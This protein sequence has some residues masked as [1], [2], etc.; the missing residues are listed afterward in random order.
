MANNCSSVTGSNLVVRAKEEIAYGQSENTGFET[1]YVKSNSINFSQNEVESEL[2]TAGR[3][4]SRTGK[5]NIEVTGSLE[6]AIDNVSTGF[7]LKQLLGDY[8]VAAAGAKFNHTFKISDTCTPSFQV[9]KGLLGTDI[10]Y[11]SVGL[12]ANSLSLD[13]GGEGEMIGTVDVIGKNEYFTSVQD[14]SPVASFSVD[15]AIN[16][17]NITLVDASALSAGDTVTLAVKKGTVS[18]LATAGNSVIA[19][20]AGEGVNFASGNFIKLG[21]VVYQVKAVSTDLLYLSRSLEIDVTATTIVLNV[22][23]TNKIES[24]TGNDIVLVNGIKQALV[25][26]DDSL[27]GIA[28]VAVLNDQSFEH[29]EVGITSTSGDAI[30]ATVETMAFT[31]ANNS[32]GKRLLN[33]KGL[34]GKVFDGK[35]SI[36]CELTLLFDAS[37]ARFIEE[38]K[39]GKEFDIVIECV[40]NTG[41]SLK[42]TMPTG[43]LTPVTPEISSP[44]AISTTVTYRP[45]KDGVNDAIVFELLNTK[46][47]Y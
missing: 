44:T 26:A 33:D 32:E 19:V 15:Y 47:T 28:N 23:E 7:W 42:I 43:T 6:V 22:S 2:M 36:S 25:A 38:S 14:D 35:V 24:V 5:G 1:I 12:K 18:A 41:D 11:K 3:S 31:F 16:T 29:F 13:F 30:T 20:G 9:E 46:A 10:N 40:N 37:N 4:P 34:V 8:S 17:K 27:Y 21:N 39:L 45:F